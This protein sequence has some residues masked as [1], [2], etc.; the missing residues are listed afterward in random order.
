MPSQRISARRTKTINGLLNE[1]WEIRPELKDNQATTIL[2]ALG[3][4]KRELNSELRMLTP[5]LESEPEPS[6]T[7]SPANS[8]MEWE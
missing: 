2:L 8:D 5:A 6:E 1:I 3:A 4:L 7:A